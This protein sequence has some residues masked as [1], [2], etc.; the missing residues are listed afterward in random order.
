M[1][2]RLCLGEYAKN[3][4]EPENMGIVIYSVE[5]LC[6]FIRENA[7]LLEEGLMNEALI[8]WLEKECGLVSLAEELKKALRKKVSLKAFVDILL[9]YTGF[10]SPRE[11]KEILESIMENSSMT[12]SQKRKAKADA[13]LE[14]G[15][16]GLAGREYGRL[17][18]QTE[19]H[20]KEQRSRLYH[21][22]GVCL[23]RLFYFEAAGNYFLKAYQLGGRMDSLQQYLL[24]L[25]LSR[26]EEEYLEYLRENEEIYEDSLRLEEE[27]EKWKA[28]WQESHN[29]SL[30]ERI[31]LEKQAD[32][33]SYQDRLKERIEYLKDAYREMVTIQSHAN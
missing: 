19:H 3:G 30:L 33:R 29:A 25:R 16:I 2:I 4:Y 21:G 28:D 9:E 6:F 12:I 8:L 27:L 14:R 32:P 23:A 17:L 7:C 22:C 11:K 5:E 13:L 20:E 10:F 26:P 18:E 31:R 1:S 15:Q 24:A